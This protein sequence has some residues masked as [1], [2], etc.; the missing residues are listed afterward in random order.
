MAKIYLLKHAGATIGRY[1]K[2]SQAEAQMR[3][4]QKHTGNYYASDWYVVEETIQGKTYKK[5]FGE[6]WD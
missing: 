5:I 2:K 3:R 6:V 4:L 1:N